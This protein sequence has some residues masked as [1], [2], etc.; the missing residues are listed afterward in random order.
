[1]DLLAP[2]RYLTFLKGHYL[3]ARVRWQTQSRKDDVLP[4][5]RA[6]FYHVGV[7]RKLCVHTRAT[8]FRAAR[9]QA[10][11]VH[12]Y[13]RIGFLIETMIQGI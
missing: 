4:A 12:R 1:M 2:D 7:F 9:P 13:V 8:V 3:A 5:P 10:F 11:C 6:T